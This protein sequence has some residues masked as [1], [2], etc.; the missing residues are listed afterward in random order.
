MSGRNFLK[1]AAVLGAA[2]LIVKIIGAIYRIPL[3][4]L[5]GTEGIGYYQPAYQVVLGI[6]TTSGSLRSFKLLI[7]ATI[8]CKIG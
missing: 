7:A 3:T 1:G 4:N 8:I 2:G 6:Q 5:I